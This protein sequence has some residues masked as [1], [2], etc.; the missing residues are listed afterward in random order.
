VLEKLDEKAVASNPHKCAACLDCEKVCEV[1]AIK[2][3]IL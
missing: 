3:D 1:K 2:I